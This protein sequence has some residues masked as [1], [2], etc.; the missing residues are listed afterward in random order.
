MLPEDTQKHKESLA[1]VD[2]LVTAGSYEEAQNGLIALRQEFPSSDDIRLRMDILEPLVRA[3]KLA[4]EGKTAFDHGEY[5]EAVRALTQAL[6]LNPQDKEAQELKTRALQERDRLRQV[7]EALT[8]GQRAMRDGDTNTAAIELQKVLQID[9]AHQQATGL[10]GQIQNV[11]AEQQQEVRLRQAMKQVD[12]LVL[13]SKF[14]DA[15]FTLLELR[16]EFPDSTEIDQRL[17]ALD[18]QSKLHVLMTDGQQALDHAEFGEAVRIFTEAQQLA[19]NDG[20]VRDM[21]V[22]AVQERDRLRQVRE[23]ISGGQ[24]ALR[25][26]EPD[27]AEKQFQRALQLDPAN[28]Q[29]STLLAQLVTERE[30][31]ERE[32]KLKAG[33]SL[34]ENLIAWKKFDEAE[35]HLAELQQEYPDS[36]GVVALAEVLLQKKAEAA[37]LPP[38]PA[39]TANS[40]PAIRRAPAAD[41][42][43][44]MA[45]AEELCQSLLKPRAPAP[46]AAAKGSGPS[47]PPPL[48]DSNTSGSGSGPVATASPGNSGAAPGNETLVMGSGFRTNTATPKPVPPPAIPPPP[49]SSVAVHPAA[50]LSPPAVPIAA[51]R[52]PLVAKPIPPP[53]SSRSRLSPV[54]FVVLGV[55]T[56]VLAVVAFLIFRHA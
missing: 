11:Q 49:P 56:A 9:P 19:P 43:R 33:L 34:A 27:V 5:G 42:A 3:V 6:E 30:A 41:Y 48:K 38:A 14:D 20:R 2:S 51:R 36:P 35:R 25:Q 10:M 18:Q 55:L 24:R 31:R 50:P 16:Q 47:S 23:A 8:A 52:P 53:V 29:A 54:V 37:A 32:Q 22:R 1:Q 46:S 40:R 45:L 7:R 39:V 26:G 17:R 21:K 15:Q 28:N 13:E 12:D 44:S 4:R